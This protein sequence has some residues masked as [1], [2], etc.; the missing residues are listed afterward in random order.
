[1][2]KQLILIVALST[3]ASFAQEASTPVVA[4]SSAPN[5]ITI[6][7][8]TAIDYTPDEID[9]NITLK[10]YVKTDPES[11]QTTTIDINEL[12]NLLIEKLKP[13]GYKKN[14]LNLSNINDM[15]LNQN[16]GMYGIQ[17]S[18]YSNTQKRTL[19]KTF[20]LSWKKSAN[21]LQSFMEAMRF[22]GVH[23]IYINSSISNAKKKELNKKL[24]EQ[25]MSEAREQAED[26]SDMTGK[27]LGEVVSVNIDPIGTRAILNEASAVYPYYNQYNNFY[28]SN[29]GQLSNTT[30]SM[31]ASIVFELTD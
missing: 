28:G 27:T 11:Q 20:V 18:L 12:E 25:V 5:T 7:H 26:V 19:Q 1:M 16:N 10:E 17:S 6:Q 23:T 2:Y 13:F 29:N 30:I 15:V 21:Q 22:T 4:A 9:I 31:V 24:M 14:D 8:R 3:T